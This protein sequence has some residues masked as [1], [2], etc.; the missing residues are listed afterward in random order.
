MYFYV[1][2]CFTYVYVPYVFSVLGGQKRVSDLLGLEIHT[3][4]CSCK[5]SNLSPLE[6]Q[7]MLLTIE[8]SFQPPQDLSDTHGLV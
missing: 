8:P 2:G 4:P 7:L 5:D 1:C 3:D 6:E